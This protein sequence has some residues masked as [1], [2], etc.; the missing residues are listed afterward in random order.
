MKFSTNKNFFHKVILYTMRDTNDKCGLAGRLLTNNI[1]ECLNK[2][3][4]GKFAQLWKEATSHHQPK[5]TNQD[6][7]RGNG[8]QKK[9]EKQNK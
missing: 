8:K 5:S 7:N 6:V 1:E 4:K 9:K 2:W 3:E